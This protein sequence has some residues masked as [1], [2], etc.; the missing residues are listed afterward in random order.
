MDSD[1]SV[2]VKFVVTEKTGEEES[3]LAHE[4]DAHM[5][6]YLGCPEYVAC[7]LA[8]GALDDYTR[9]LFW[10][11]QHSIRPDVPI[12]PITTTGKSLFVQRFYPGGS[13]W[14]FLLKTAA[15][16]TADDW[17]SISA[18]V[19]ICLATLQ[20]KHNH[21]WAH[22]DLHLS[23]IVIDI[24]PSGLIIPHRHT[25]LTHDKKLVEMTIPPF[26]G[27]LWIRLVDFEYCERGKEKPIS[28][29]F[30]MHMFFHCILQYLDQLIETSS[31][32]LSSITSEATH[33]TS[34]VR[35]EYQKTEGFIPESVLCFWY[36]MV[37]EKVRYKEYFGD[38]TSMEHRQ[39][40]S[41]MRL[42]DY[43]PVVTTPHDT[44]CKHSFFNALRVH[45]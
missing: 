20:A 44:L 43:D 23:N 16:L 31:S 6:A 22:R 15:F 10:S 5:D 12:G 36:D 24:D 7:P 11:H 39:R 25:L 28:C 26:C 45:S 21:N 38:M 34:D 32:A 29:Y 14:K 37:P 35:K 19:L 13:L 30:D 8:W 3:K 9:H 1:Q 42:R 18:Q 2:V 33:L 17:R 40:I 4:V 27:N 41:S